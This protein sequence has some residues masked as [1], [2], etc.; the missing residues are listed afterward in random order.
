MP[1]SIWVTRQSAWQFVTFGS[2]GLSLGVV[3]AE[4]GTV[5]LRSPQS[6]EETFYYGGAGV[7]LAAGLKIPRIGRVQIN[8]PRGPLTGSGGPT[9]FPST[10]SLFITA[11]FDGSELSLSD[12]QGPCIFTEV[13]GGII[14]GGSACAMYVG[15][16]PLTLPLISVPAFGPQLVLNSAKGLLLMAG[17]NVGLQAQIGGAV[18]FGYLR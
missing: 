8:T 9:A 17:L 16:N 10:G 13:G 4:G 3:A 15:I 6:R 2:G 14:G 12:I 7:G 1:F 5:V 18:Y 11:S